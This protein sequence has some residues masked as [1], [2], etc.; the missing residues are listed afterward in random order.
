MAQWNRVCEKNTINSRS[1]CSDCGWL[2]PGDE[3]DWDKHP[4]TIHGS[5]ERV[6][7]FKNENDTPGMNSD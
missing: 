7:R 4:A 2:D 3:H 1:Y 5:I 6:R